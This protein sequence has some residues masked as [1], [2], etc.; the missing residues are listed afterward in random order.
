M[1]RRQGGVRPASVLLIRPECHATT[2]DALCR[3]DDRVGPE[4]WIAQPTPSCPCE[5][6]NGV[7]WLAIDAGLTHCQKTDQP[8]PLADEGSPE[9]ASQRRHLVMPGSGHGLISPSLILKGSQRSDHPQLRPPTRRQECLNQVNQPPE[10][11]A[12]PTITWHQ[13][14]NC[15]ATIR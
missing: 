11:P 10:L 12:T 13:A 6:A 5:R 7:G 15:P 9:R 14:L 1:G 3:H 8:P 2:S 4:L